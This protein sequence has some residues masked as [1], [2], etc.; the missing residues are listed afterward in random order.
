MLFKKTLINFAMIESVLLMASINIG[1]N[2]PVTEPFKAC[3]FIFVFF[4]AISLLPA[5]GLSLVFAYLAK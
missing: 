1:V 5:L 2:L 4:A 3:L